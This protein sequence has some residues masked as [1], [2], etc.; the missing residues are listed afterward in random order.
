MAKFQMTPRIGTQAEPARAGTKADP[1]TDADTGKAVK[2][3]GESQIDLAG[4]GDEI[5]GFLVSVEPGTQ[6]GFVIGGFAADGYMEVDTGSVPVGTAV[7]VASNPAK[8]TAG[9]TVVKA[10]AEG[11]PALYKWVVV[12]P[13]LVRRV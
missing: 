5:F 8:G 2:L 6:D 1:L 10:G 13:N 3:V 11:A 4:D 12:H 9:K 7:V